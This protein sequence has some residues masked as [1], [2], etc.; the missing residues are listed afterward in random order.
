MKKRLSKYTPRGYKLSVHRSL[1]GN[2]LFADEDIPKGMCIIEYIGRVV[3]KEEA[4]NDE[5]KYLF[6]VGPKGKT[7]NGNI[8][9]NVARY[10]NHSCAPNCEAYG[11]A[12]RVFIFSRKRISAGTELTYNYGKEYFEKFIKP[13]GC[14]CAKHRR[15]TKRSMLH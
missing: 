1:A 11:P 7:I 4:E 3:S 6:E 13:K 5:G 2:G 8:P 9:A 14:R 10:I 15:G 12:G